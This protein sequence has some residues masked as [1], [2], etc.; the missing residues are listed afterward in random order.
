MLIGSGAAGVRV[1][2]PPGRVDLDPYAERMAWFPPEPERFVG[3][4][5]ALIEASAALAPES[6][7]AG[8]LFV[9]MAGAGK[10]A[11]ALELAHQRRGRFGALAWWQAPDQPDEFGQALAGFAA[12]VEAQLGIPMLQA[13]GS[14]AGHR[15]FLP[16]LAAVLREG[17]GAA[18][19][20]AP[21]P[22]SPG[23]RAAAPATRTDCRS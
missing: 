10:S 11:C 21:P 2:S 12:V 16:R 23:C 22:D 17:S 8:V 15:S 1:A 9:G 13:V 7:R 4:T 5:Q 6:G 20:G 3:R 19:A 14:E 18:G